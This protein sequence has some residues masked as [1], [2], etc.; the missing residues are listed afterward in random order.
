MKKILIFAMIVS[1]A[2]VSC[3][4][5]KPDEPVV[6]QSPIVY[7][8]VEHPFLGILSLAS[9]QTWKVTKDTIITQEWTDAI[10]ATKCQKETY[11]GWGYGEDSVNKVDL[12]DCRSNPNQ[13]GDL[14]SWVAVSK[15]K[16]VLCPNGW[17]V[18][19]V[20]DFINLDKALGGTGAY[21]Q[22]DTILRDKYLN[23][24]GGAYGGY[25][26]SD[27]TLFLQG[28][29]AFYWS[30]SGTSSVDVAC[31]MSFRADGIVN[32]NDADGKKNGFTLR[33]VK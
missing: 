26:Y 20:S 6:E 31:N 24:W 29:Y 7:P 16:D 9:N 2:L 21:Y 15:Y 28:S 22:N 5:N 33:C 4:K 30:Q 13:K 32:A 8:T 3:K 25:C 23:S 10:T 11:R 1:L 27:G 18:P 17:R 12:A 14:F 19:T